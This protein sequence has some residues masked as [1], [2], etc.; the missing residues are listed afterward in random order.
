[1]KK[2]F[3]IVIIALLLGALL[4]V[5]VGCGSN[6]NNEENKEIAAEET[7]VDETLVKINNLEFHLDKEAKFKD[8]KYTIVGDFK[9]AEHERYIQ[10][11]YYQEDQTNL[12]FF[13]IFYYN[14]Q[15]IED[16]LKDLGIEGEIDFT[17]GK[18]D[19]LEYKYYAEPKDDGTIHFYFIN[20][21]EDTYTINFVSKYDIKDFEEKVIK[22]LEF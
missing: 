20:H 17:D 13:R 10:Y 9:E 14:K 8:I 11:N 18:T 15:G 22:S 16:A 3:S 21:D 2:I 5:L 12:L 19:N 4:F 6:S 7:V 1:M